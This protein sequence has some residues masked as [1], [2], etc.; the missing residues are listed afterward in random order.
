MRLAPGRYIIIFQQQ[1]R[2]RNTVNDKNED[3]P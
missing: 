3:G 2:L 1:P